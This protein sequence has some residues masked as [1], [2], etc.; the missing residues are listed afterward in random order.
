MKITFFFF[1]ICISIIPC[2]AQNKPA[3]ASTAQRIEKVINSDWT[4]NYFP[5]ETADKG[6]EAATYDDSKWPAV[7]IPHT[8]FTY[9][10]TGELHPFIRNAAETDNP[11][12]WNGWGWYRKHFTINQAYADRK[13]FIEFEGVQKY[14]KVWVNGVYLG[15]HKGG[16]G[17][18]DFDITKHIKKGG[19]NVIAVAVN[20]RR[21]DS[22]RIPPMTAGNFNV[23]G[24]IYRDVTI[25]LKNNLYIPMQGSA[26]H[27]GGTFITT[28]GLTEKSGVVRIQT[29]VKNDNNQ[30]R[31]CILQTTIFDAQGK[32]IQQVKSEAEIKAGQLYTFDQTTKPVKPHLW[33]P[34]D[35]YMYKVVSEVIVGKSVVDI[36]NSPL[37]FRWF[38]WDYSQN[39]LY[40]NGKK[41]LLH[42][43]NR[44]QEYPWLGDAIP[45]WI[46]LMDYTDM[47]ENMGYN[48]VRTA[49]YPN[50]RMVYDLTDK[51]G[52][53]VDE[54]VPNIK[55]L[56]FSPEVQQQQ[57]SEMIRRDRNHPSIMFWSMGNETNKAVDSKIAVAEDTTR[58]LT[59]RRVTNDSKGAFAKHNDDN[60][61]IE[62]LLRCSVRGWYNTDVKNLE[63]SDEQHSGTEEHQMNMLIKSGLLGTGNLSTWLYEDHGAD[64]EYLNAPMLHVNPKGYVDLYRVPKYAY[65]LWQATY[66]KNPMIFILPH[67][68]RQQYIG[69]KKDIVVTSNCD[70][71]ELMVNG[72]SK[73]VQVP[74]QLNFHTVTFNGI[75]VEN[76]VLSATGTK[77]G[78][79]V[80]WQ[81][82]MA[83]DPAVIVLKASHGKIAADRGAVAVIHA[84]I[85]DSRG[86]HIYGASNTLKWT[87]T[88]PAKLV[89]PT[90]YNSDINNHHDMEGTWYMDVPVA[91]VI[92]STGEPG[93]I[94]V[95]VSAGGLASGSVEV[96]AEAVKPDNSVVSETI[97]KNDGRTGVARI[98]LQAA[99]LEEIP[100]EIESTHDIIK[101]V[102]PDKNGYRKLIR[103][104]LAKNNSSA[105]STSVEFRTLT[106]LFATYLFNNSGQLIADDYNF[107][108]NHF[109]NCRLIAGYINATKLPLPFKDG[110]RSYYS[111]TIIK[112]GSEKNAGDEMN[113][114]NW[115]PS[116]GTVVYYSDEMKA[117]PVKGTVVSSKNELPDLISVV[118]PSF[119][120]FSPEAKERALEF[121]A[122]MNPYVHA[123]VK[124]EVVDGKKVT[125][126]KLL[127][128][129]NKPVLIPLF[130]FIAE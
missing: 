6:Y 38:K 84:D 90:V 129:K 29:W 46:T 89:G 7:S 22:F 105:D 104:Y 126:T 80:T 72:I 85:T 79:T 48:F 60:L 76:A 110:L 37:G 73:G 103:D 125:I 74:D 68:W 19:D 42:G 93:K 121:I 109:N 97:L 96:L 102:A 64:R 20:N 71:V 43:G 44:H 116:G 63:P 88:G 107:N 82:P 106:D 35:P 119:S 81:L 13:V 4:F 8:W 10:T 12:W 34:E 101:L 91:N 28:P 123:D 5:S 39:I 2:F 69:Q 92:R 62:N 75:T 65:Y 59:A 114:L 17:S 115:I 25:S 16:Y 21:N 11:Y 100:R 127:A 98:V 47:A 49:H 54:E 31:N 94:K 108:V 112:E 78:K 27:E 33:S 14:C 111:K 120:Q 77:N 118:H 23:Y 58:I 36:Y 122:K 53:V 50:D 51:F 87:V 117:P 83:G 32:M 26:A 24:G 57:L 9:E 70:R 52:I 99:R 18:F 86:S 3:T 41:T 67:F 15:D 130:K 55:N 30:A 45:K 40:V 113:W 61:P 1:L 95:T 56:D 128:E 124:S 66:A